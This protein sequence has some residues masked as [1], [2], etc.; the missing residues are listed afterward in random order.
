M[1]NNSEDMFMEVSD[2]DFSSESY[3]DCPISKSNCEFI[4]GN[5]SR[6]I[7]IDPSKKICEIRADIIVNRKKSVRIWG[8]VKDCKGHPVQCALVK[9]VK[10]VVKC[11]KVEYEG[12]AHVVTDCLGFY[13]FDICVPTT[14][15]FLVIVSK[16][17]VGGELE[18]KPSTECNPC[19]DHCGCVR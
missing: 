14:S 7:K 11:G 9:L 4:E 1:G 18:L 2:I 16:P 3:D 12:V 13:Q 10:K 19:R 17:S 6:P 15:E 8:Q 5:V